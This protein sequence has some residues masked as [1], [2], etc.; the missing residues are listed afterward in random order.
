MATK[1]TFDEATKNSLLAVVERFGQTKA[2]SLRPIFTELADSISKGEI[3]DAYQARY[4]RDSLT[5]L[6][7]E[8][9]KHTE[10]LE[11]L[12]KTFFVIE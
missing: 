12:E 4:M 5:L 10:F 1:L 9:G 6:E 3:S 11:L 8:E 2:D 7:G